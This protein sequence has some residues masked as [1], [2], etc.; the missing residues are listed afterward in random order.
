MG[1]IHIYFRDIQ[2]NVVFFQELRDGNVNAISPYARA[3][4]GSTQV[5]GT[6]G[7]YMGVWKDF[8]DGFMDC[9]RRGNEFSFYWAIYDPVKKIQHTRHHKVWV[10]V[11]HH[12]MA[13]IASIQIHIGKF[14]NAEYLQDA[15]IQ[16]LKVYDESPVLQENQIP[17]IVKRGDILVVDNATGG[18]WLN[19]EEFFE[20]LD[21]MSKFIKFSKGM[22]GVSVSPAIVTNG[23][24]EFRERWL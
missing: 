21:P 14:A 10:D 12:H 23:R 15:Y 9:A 16:T 7:A 4:V 8:R 6:Y 17:Y 18:I 11:N 24:V 19:G 2:G 5:E 3:I 20:Y 13:K 22:N 1:R